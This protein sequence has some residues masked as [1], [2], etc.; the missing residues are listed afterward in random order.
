MIMRKFLYT[1]FIFSMAFVS[2]VNTLKSEIEKQAIETFKM[3]YAKEIK[4]AE[5]ESFKTV[6]FTQNLC[7]LHVE[8]NSVNAP[9]KYEYLFFT[10]DGS[11]YEALQDLSQDS[12]FV[13]ENTLKKIS[14]GKIYEN[15]DYEKATFFRAASYINTFGREVGNHNTD[16]TLRIPMKTGLWEI[17]DVVDEFSDKV[18]SNCLRLIGKGTF[19]NSIVTN[20]K[21]IALL[22][23]D[24]NYNC[25]LQLVEYENGVVKD[26]GGTIKIKDGEG[27]VHEIYFS[28]S[29]AG[30]IEPTSIATK[31]EF[32]MIIE[33]EGELSAI[34][35]T[36]GW[37]LSEK[38]SYKFKF[39]LDGFKKAMNYI[40]PSEDDVSV[41]E[42]EE[43]DSNIEEFNH[44]DIDEKMDIPIPEAELTDSI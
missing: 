15:L 38:K 17:C 29:S 12:I 34:A 42:Y 27:D 40:R 44:E 41:T 13:S 3:S 30:D 6:F 28:K 4:D 24:E 31:M 10:Q 8:D 35:N 9:K 19:S 26:F 39:N 23:V 36:S 20:E 21:L 37:L 11:N 1:L 25:S 18:S 14:K 32:K 33:K 22:F 43:I 5:F 7:I 2:C 16:F